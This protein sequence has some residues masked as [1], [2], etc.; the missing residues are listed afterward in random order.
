MKLHVIQEIYHHMIVWNEFRLF[1]NFN[2]FRR[3]KNVYDH[4]KVNDGT[5]GVEKEAY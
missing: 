4:T 5:F 3:G 1:Q 2:Y